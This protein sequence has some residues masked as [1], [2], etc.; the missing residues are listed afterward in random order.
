MKELTLNTSLRHEDRAD[1]T[2][3]YIYNTSGVANNALNGTTNWNSG[4]QTRT[5]LKADGIYRLPAGYSA[6]FGVDWERKK[7]PLPPANTALFSKQIFFRPALTETGVHAELR[8]AISMSVMGALGFEYKQRRGNSD[9]WVTTS[10]TVGNPLISFDPSAPA[11]ITDAGGNYV[12]PDMYMDRNRTKLRG[13]ADWEVT[14]KLSLQAVIEH[15][16][17]RFLR[18]FPTSITPAQIVPID[19]GARSITGESASLDSSYQINDDWKV[20]G[21]WTRSYNRWNVNKANLGDDTRNTG[22]T[23]GL[24]VSGKA[25][26]RW[27]VALDILSA[28]DKTRFTNVVA[29]GNTGGAGNIAGSSAQPLPGNILP[30]ISYQTDKVNLRGKYA[31]NQVS[32][33]LLRLTFQRFR[34]DD[35]Q[36]TYNGVPFLYSD[37]TTVSQPTSQV[38][39]FVSASYVIRF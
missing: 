19:A 2:P 4:S 27:T 6:M 15:T 14:E 35:W 37:N 1:K 38:L 17:D 10:G 8:K 13:N 24:G 16:Q 3:I 9:G 28:H 34:T 39:R 20:N 30:A 32:D 33:V 5:T 26:S 22:D 29:T 23:M 21:F 7:T 36:W 18:S 31:M 12:L 11:V 25:S